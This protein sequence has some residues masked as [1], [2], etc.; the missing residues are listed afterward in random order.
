MN[1]SNT[2]KFWLMLAWALVFLTLAFLMSQSID[3]ADLFRFS[4]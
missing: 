3:P 2:H 1:G 4:H